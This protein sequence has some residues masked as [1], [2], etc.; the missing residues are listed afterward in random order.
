M[1]TEINTTIFFLSSL[2]LFVIYGKMPFRKK[3]AYEKYEPTTRFKI[4]VL[5]FELES[6]YWREYYTFVKKSYRVCSVL[7]RTPEA[8][9]CLVAIVTFCEKT[10][11]MKRFD[12][13]LVT[14]TMAELDG[15]KMA[16]S[17]LR[18]NTLPL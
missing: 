2:C 15:K 16:Y 1:T 9:T 6:I 5:Q 17:N 10:Q 8:I 13:V 3:F 4:M 12:I 18:A 7:E 11:L 14:E